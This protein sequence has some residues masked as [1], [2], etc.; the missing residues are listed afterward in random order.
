MLS[1]NSLCYTKKPNILSS[2]NNINIICQAGI[3]S[4]IQRNE[5][6]K[7]LID[8]NFVCWNAANTMYLNESYND[9]ITT[10]PVKDF[11]PH[12]FIAW[13][14][15]TEMPVKINIY[16][17]MFTIPYIKGKVILLQT[18]QC[19]IFNIILVVYSLLQVLVNYIIKSC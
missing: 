13:V 7:A 1:R 3:A 18:L 17:I 6:S 12:M 2:N 14:L 5:C 4:V 16:R 8:I 9:Q 19:I 11:L 15:N 10:P